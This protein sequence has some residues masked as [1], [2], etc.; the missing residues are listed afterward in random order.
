MPLIMTDAAIAISSV[1]VAA[2]ALWV[3][4]AGT[5]ILLHS[6]VI[7]SANAQ[8]TVLITAEAVGSPQTSETE[9]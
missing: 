5:G 2:I 4:L 8:M 3:A 6:G 1:I 9:P 7:R